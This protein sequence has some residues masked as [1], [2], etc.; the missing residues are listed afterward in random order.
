MVPMSSALYEQLCAA[1]DAPRTPLDDSSDGSS[2][3]RPSEQPSTSA[4][5]ADGSHAAE[6]IHSPDTLLFFIPALPYRMIFSNL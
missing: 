6:G 4:P 5:L 2:N 1:A 3:V